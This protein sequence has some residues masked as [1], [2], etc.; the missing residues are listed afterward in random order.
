MARHV[1]YLYSVSVHTFFGKSRVNVATASLT[2]RAS[3][4][5]MI[6]TG[7]TYTASLIGPRRKKSERVTSGEL[8]G[9]VIGLPLST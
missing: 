8:G 4:D 7:G 5:K 2:H 3:C 9:Q 1:S 6:A